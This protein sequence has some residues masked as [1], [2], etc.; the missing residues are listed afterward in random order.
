LSVSFAVTLKL[1]LIARNLQL[2][3][4]LVAHGQESRAHPK[5][6]NSSVVT[7]FWVG[8]ENLQEYGVWPFRVGS[9][10]S[11][12]CKEVIEADIQ[13]YVR[14][15][16]YSI[17]WRLRNPMAVESYEWPDLLQCCAAAI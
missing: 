11:L 14:W 17:R 1:S 16:F 7:G 6:A 2:G 10:C 15:P 5:E 8:A 4:L 9:G 13:G 3:I 12:K